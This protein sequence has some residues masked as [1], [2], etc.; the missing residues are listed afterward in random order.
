MSSTRTHI[1]GPRVPPPQR[2]P[3]FVYLCVGMRGIDRLIGVA[4][5]LK[6]ISDLIER[7][8]YFFILR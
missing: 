6:K 2:L 8:W 4:S 1:V 7:L 3:M 5:A